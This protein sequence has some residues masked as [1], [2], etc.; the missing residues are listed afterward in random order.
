M[1]IGFIV[2]PL[3]GYGLASNM[4]GSDGM[5]LP[6]PDV[7]QSIKRAERFIDLL[8]SRNL[9]F[10]VPAGVM[11]ER[12]LSGNGNFQYEIISTAREPSTA[13]DT[14]RFVHELCKHEVDLLIFV[15]GDGTARD[16]LSANDC[17]LPVLGIPAG[18]KMYSSVFSISVESAARLV[19]D[20]LA[21]VATDTNLCEVVDINEE[22]YRKGHLEIRL[23]GEMKVPAS[24]MIVTQS[25]T[26]YAGVDFQG[27][28]EYIAE[29]IEPGR[30]YI[31]GPG[32]TCKGVMPQGAAKT[33]ILGVD[34]FIDGKVVESDADEKTIFDYASRFD[35][36][37]IVSPIGG[38]NFLFGRG[39]KQISLRTVSAVGW[40]NIWVISS[41]EKLREMANLYVDIDN[42]PDINIPRFIKVLYG[43]GRYR[44][45]RVNR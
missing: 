39:N 9:E 18:V 8:P 29:R 25:K 33:N 42:S 10:Y 27:V 26:E 2:N 20:I 36:T 3:A 41:Q 19:K 15:G 23:Y 43:Y 13:E 22:K 45:V 4:K 31:I 12:V 24:P 21:G 1:K 28:A 7:S 14:M 6:S 17:G 16:V 30:C 40:E 37:I 11:G 5:V 35:S 34:I 38:Q 44:M 32:S